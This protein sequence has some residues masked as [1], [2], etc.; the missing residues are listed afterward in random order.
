M[1]RYIDF[2]DYDENLTLKQ[3]KESIIQEEGV[4]KLEETKEKQLIIDKFENKYFKF[5]EDCSLFGKTLQVISFKNFIRS[6]RTEAWNLIY[7]F[8]GTKISFS[9]RDINSRDFQ[10][11][12]AG[13]SF[14]KKDLDSV[15]FIS[16]EEYS[17]YVQEYQNLK[18]KLEDLIEWRK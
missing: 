17:T 8:K 14:S 18:S 15:T 7:Y 4:N 2:K 9:R 12:R 6:E 16:E 13:E 5:T 3:L 1:K 11:N 10:P